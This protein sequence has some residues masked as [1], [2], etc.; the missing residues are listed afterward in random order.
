[1]TTKKSRSNRKVDYTRRYPKNRLKGRKKKASPKNHSNLAK[2]H[3]LIKKSYAA[4][5]SRAFDFPDEHI[6]RE[7]LLPDR[8]EKETELLSTKDTFKKDYVEEIKTAKISQE[9]INENSQQGSSEQITTPSLIL[10]HVYGSNSKYVRKNVRYTTRGNIVYTAGINGVELD[11]VSK[12]QTFFKGYHCDEILSMA[13]FHAHGCV[14]ERPM[15]S[16]DKKQSQK[17]KEVI[18]DGYETLIATGE[19]G[20]KP[21]IYIWESNSMK[22]LSKLCGLHSRG[23]I[24]L[25]FNKTGNLLASV[26]ADNEH[27]LVVY[28]WQSRE[29]VY[30]TPTN[31]DKVYCVRF[32]PEPSGMMVSAGIKHVYFWEPSHKDLVVTKSSLPIKGS[33]DHITIVDIVF[34]NRK[35]IIGAA[36]EGHL[37]VW[38]RK[39]I[40]TM[41][42]FE[43]GSIKMHILVVLPAYIQTNLRML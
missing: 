37:C 40:E 28:D 23:V 34:V 15:F 12:K 30:S 7:G 18:Y 39:K 43:S 33:E 2:F 1:M 42:S 35:K 16:R 17:A 22:Y 10:E 13:I 41:V 6:D 38:D 5:L 3:I 36:A 32:L 14:K 21:S 26:G 8:T 20:S 27:T 25:D 24:L 31:I 9:T 4:P 19:L 29:C 11:P